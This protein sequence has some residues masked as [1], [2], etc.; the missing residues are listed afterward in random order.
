M[1]FA[2]YY[3]WIAPNILLAACLMRILRRGLQ[4]LYPAFCCYLIL[5]L[6]LF[7]A[8]IC[9]DILCWLSLSSLQTY[10]LV[11][12]LGTAITAISGIALIYEL[13]NHLLFRHSFVAGALKPIL[14]WTSAVLLLP[15]AVGAGF[16]S[17][18]GIQRLLAAF[19]TLNFSA[20]LMEIGLLL[21][22]LLFARAL[23]VSWH[24]FATGV[25]L[26]LAVVASTELA[27][28]PLIS[29][30]GAS[31][32]VSID[33]IRLAALHVCAVVWVVYSFLPERGRKVSR[34]S[35]QKLDLDLWNGE[36]ERIAQQ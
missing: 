24:G 12:I 25:A 17:P 15:A 34:S 23:R 6:T 5:Q 20:S 33:L 21:T 28:S 4:K 13:A 1:L 11:L 26:G 31:H 3:L 27:A 2:R 8:L 29:V 16:L 10:R 19:Q 32:F 18:P 35:V 30:L 14:Q 22:L 36:L 7:S 9:I